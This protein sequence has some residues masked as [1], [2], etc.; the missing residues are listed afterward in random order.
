VDRFT[1][2]FQQMVGD[3][4]T[5]PLIIVCV[6]VRASLRARARA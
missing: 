4:I 6:R 3:L 2:T 5:S 1:R